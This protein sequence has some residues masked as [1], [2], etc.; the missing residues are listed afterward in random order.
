M[1]ASLLRKGCWWSCILLNAASLLHAAPA[2]IPTT[3]SMATQP[4]AAVYR[5]PVVFSGAVGTVASGAGVPTGTVNI[6]EGTSVLATAQL[7]ANG[8]YQTTLS[9]LGVGTHTLGAT[10]VPSGDYSASSSAMNIFA[11]TA[12]PTATTLQASPQA[13]ILGQLVTITA[14]VAI[15]P[16][17]SG[18]PL[19]NVTFFDGTTALSSG[20]LPASGTAT[21]QQVL[22]PGPHNLSAAFKPADANSLASASPTTGVTV[23][24]SVGITLTTNPALPSLGATTTLTATLAASGS[25]P[26]GV[27]TFSDGTLDLGPAT[28]NAAGQ[29]SIQTVFRTVGPH[30]IKIS[31]AGDISH[32]AVSLTTTVTVTRGVTQLSLITGAQSIL[33]GQSLTLGAQLSTPQLSPQQAGGIA[34]PTGLVTFLDGAGT[35]GTASPASGTASLAAPALVGGT[36]SLQATYAGDAN[37]LPAQS[38]VMPLTVQPRGTSTSAAL[39]ANLGQEVTISVSVAALGIQAAPTGSVQLVNSATRAVLGTFTLTA[40]VA[41]AAVTLTDANPIVAVYTGNANFA[42]S[43][44]LAV[45]VVY[46]MNAAGVA[47]PNFAAEELIA[48]FGSGFSI[49]NGVAQDQ[50]LPLTLAGVSITVLDSA[51]VNRPAP[52][53]YVS[54]TQINTMIP[55]ATANGNATMTVTT[56]LGK[57]LTIQLT[58]TPTAPGIFTA[59]SD[60]RSVAAAQILRVA[61]DGTQSV[62]SVAAY[63]TVAKQWVPAPI[64]LSS[65]AAYLVLFGTGLRNTPGNSLVTCAIRGITYTPLYAGAQNQ[66]PGLDQI[67]VLLPRSLSGA[68]V[69][70]VQVIA[71][72][73]SANV[74]TIAIR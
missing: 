39:S 43:S 2:A 14:V 31:Y 7:D 69:V 4:G 32:A 53:I 23:G 20:P 42:T 6:L 73:Q 59:N 70:T 48:L 36:H 1:S 40:G 24:G 65:G 63:D 66:F 15:A 5:Q 41:N 72:A 58:I 54:P 28:L 61:D 49:F 35:L 10:Y 21:T 38:V 55:A 56:T 11:V 34:V 12:A 3:V 37:W 45:G 60:G 51:G 8:L 13:P 27:V 68:G 30:S 46:T 67:D 44:S 22:P 52:L 47:T 64:D 50:P 26:F 25:V 71:N 17:S 18:V 62:E 57:T 16:P 74:V 29:T 33:F 19:G 9:N